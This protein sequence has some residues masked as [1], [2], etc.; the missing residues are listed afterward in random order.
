MS[1]LEGTSIKHL[2]STKEG[3]TSL[4]GKEVVYL[5]SSDIDRSGRGYFF[6]RYGMIAGFSPR[7]REMAIDTTENY[8]AFT[9]DVVEMVLR[10]EAPAT[11]LVNEGGA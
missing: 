3:R 7:G 9:S 4:V 10:P 6:P 5:T 1:R 8:V 2:L 11:T